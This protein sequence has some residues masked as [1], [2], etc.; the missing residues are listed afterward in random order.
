MGQFRLE[1]GRWLEN[2]CPLPL[3]LNGF[4]FIILSVSQIW[5]NILCCNLFFDSDRSKVQDSDKGTNTGFL[6]QNV[7]LLPYHSHYC[8]FPK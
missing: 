7:L 2:F 8:V 6:L 1:V 3:S 4:H 5:G